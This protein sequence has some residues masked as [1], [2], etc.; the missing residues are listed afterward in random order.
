MVRHIRNHRHLNTEQEGVILEYHSESGF[1][2][3]HGG[4]LF[5]LYGKDY[6]LL[7]NTPGK[8]SIFSKIKFIQKCKILKNIGKMLKPKIL[9]NA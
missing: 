5:N 7:T 4:N 2:T 3:N 9:V 6:P 8:K 1:L